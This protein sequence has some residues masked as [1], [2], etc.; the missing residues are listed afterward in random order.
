MINKHLELVS[1]Q[2]PELSEFLNGPKLLYL[3]DL[4]K[5]EFNVNIDK[6][7]KNSNNETDFDWIRFEFVQGKTV[8]NCSLKPIQIQISIGEKSEEE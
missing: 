4:L 6:I 8:D 5:E 2:Q 3:K 7:S 1:Y